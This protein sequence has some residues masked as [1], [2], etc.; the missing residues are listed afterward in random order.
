MEKCIAGHNFPIWLGF[1]GGKGVATSAGVM[2]G[3]LPLASLVGFVVW[4]IVFF[5]TR[6]V[7]VASMTGACALALAVLVIPGD[8]DRWPVFVL[9]LVAV[10]LIFWRHRA[11]I[12]RLRNG[13]EHRWEK[14]K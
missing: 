11:N 2:F 7:S 13:T 6:Y 14:K 1:K 9:A 10:I 5:S 8:P 4:V 12:E 3:L